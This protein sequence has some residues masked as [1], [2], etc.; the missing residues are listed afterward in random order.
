MIRWKFKSCPHCGGDI[1]IEKNF[2][3]LS[4]H[5]LQCGYVR[6]IEPALVEK[7]YTH[8][9]ERELINSY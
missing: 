3:E 6:F 8:H 1:Y 7:F 5:C 2:E 9:Q 4:E